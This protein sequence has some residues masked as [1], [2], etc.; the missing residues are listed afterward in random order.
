MLAAAMT[1]PTA[2]LQKNDPLAAMPRLDRHKPKCGPVRKSKAGRWRAIVL[3]GIHVLIGVHLLQWLWTGRTVTPVEP[4]EASYLLDAGKLNA[5]FV[6]FAVLILGTLVFGRW[7]CGWACHV[8]AVQDLCAWMLGKLG[9]RPRPLR[10]R[11][12]VLVPFVVAYDM[13]VGSQVER[14]L[15]GVPNQPVEPQF[16]TADLW[17]RFP[18]PLMGVLTIAVVG[19]LIVWWLGAKGFCTY[20]CPYGAFFGVADRFAVGRIKVSDACDACGHCTSVCSSNVRVHEEVAIHRQIVD[21]AC[22][23]C[24]DCVSVCPKDAL[25]FGLA[26]PKP[27][28]ISQ[29][30]IQARADFTW[31]EEVALGAIAWLATM[32][33]RGAWFG[34]G[35]P[36]LLAVGLGVITAAMV[37]LGWRLLRANDV[38]FQH[39]P[40]KSGGRLRPRGRM[41]FGAVALWLVFAVHAGVVSRESKAAV[42]DAGRLIATLRRTGQSDPTAFGAIEQ[43]MAAIEDWSLA[44]DPTLLGA[45]GLLLR[46]LGRHEDA[47]R[48]LERMTSWRGLE[49]R[50]YW[51]H[52]AD[53]ALANYYLG[54]GRRDEA[55]RLARDVLAVEPENRTARALL[56]LIEQGPR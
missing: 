48:S 22:M 29:Q 25:S 2:P 17:E 13:F 8:V 39:T 37:V 16:T 40:L 55:A 45:H 24:M 47:V 34:E 5:G 9:L 53:N 11:L 3:I 42:T 36:F 12:L 44:I 10:S 19:G 54:M 49:P 6:L 46:E 43:R 7:F 31:P 56:D 52:S 23:K 26:L 33:F 28:Q 35:I 30:R 51:L 14:W 1:T 18:G 32:G 15:A 20:G 50:K 38:S 21:P 41:V 4:S 27:F